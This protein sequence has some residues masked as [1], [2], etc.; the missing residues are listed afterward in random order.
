MS[1]QIRV[2]KNQKA[3]KSMRADLQRNAKN[4]QQRNREIVGVIQSWIQEFRMRNRSGS[5]VSLARQRG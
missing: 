1:S 3:D 5:E 4:E 2:V